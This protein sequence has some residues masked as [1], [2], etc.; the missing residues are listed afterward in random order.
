MPTSYDRPLDGGG[1]A[2]EALAASAPSALWSAAPGG[3]ASL[4]FIGQIFD[5]Y[6]V[7]E[8]DGRVVLIDQHAAHERVAF[9]RLR[10]ERARGGVARD[11]LLIPEAI[12]LPAAHAAA[13]GEHAEVLAAAG[14]EGEPFGDGTFLLRT[15]PH[16][17][18]GRDAGALVRAVARDARLPQRRAGR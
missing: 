16:L 4:R 6:F 13:L 5:G 14:L 9:E 2:L 7:C 17:L 12:E 18:R 1:F 15:V 8:G 11:P 3:F 10:A